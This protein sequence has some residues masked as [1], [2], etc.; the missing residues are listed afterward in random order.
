M[1]VDSDSDYE[2][3]HKKKK[4]GSKFT[5]NID[6]EPRKKRNKHFKRAQTVTSLDSDKNNN[7]QSFYRRN[8]PNKSRRKQRSESKSSES[9]ISSN[10]DTDSDDIPIKIKRKQCDEIPIK[11]KT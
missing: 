6:A 1:G 2:R 9:E 8:K 5:K 3:Y 4:K 10:S 7:F 11:V